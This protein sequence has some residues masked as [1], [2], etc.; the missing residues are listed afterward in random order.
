M[1]QAQACSQN[2]CNINSSESVFGCLEYGWYLITQ[3]FKRVTHFWNVLLVVADPLHPVVFEC[4]APVIAGTD[5]LHRNIFALVILLTD[6]DYA[7]LLTLQWITDALSY[8]FPPVPAR[9]KKAKQKVE[10]CVCSDKHGCNSEDAT[11]R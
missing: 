8:G 4:L 7:F 3:H 9:E 11:H 6:N 10:F 1:E 5:L 2:F